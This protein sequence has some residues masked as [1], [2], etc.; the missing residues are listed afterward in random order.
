MLRGRHDSEGVPWQRL[1][2][3]MVAAA[4]ADHP[5]TANGLRACTH[6]CWRRG[7]LVQTEL[8]SSLGGEIGSGVGEIGSGAGL[9]TALLGHGLGGEAQQ[10]W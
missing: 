4:H 3:P 8:G 5:H 9:V 2:D 1:A 6:A 7:R 10:S